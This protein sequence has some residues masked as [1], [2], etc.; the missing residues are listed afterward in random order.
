VPFELKLV[1]STNLNP[2]SLGDDAFLRRLRNKVHVGA[3]SAEAFGWVLEDSA[4][5][6]DIELADDAVEHLI[7]VT[8][9]EIGELRPYLAVDFC[10]LTVAVCEYEQCQQ[11]L[12]T[13]MID[14]VAELYF[15]QQDPGPHDRADPAG[16]LAPTRPLPSREPARR[17]APATPQRRASDHPMAGLDALAATL[18]V[19]DETGDVPAAL[20]PSGDGGSTGR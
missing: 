12:D 8:R 11:V 6:H 15:V 4:H 14:R 20:R 5:D 3:I 19:D 1:I 17:T 18:S 2:M 10:E 16:T 9:R 7:R 13:A